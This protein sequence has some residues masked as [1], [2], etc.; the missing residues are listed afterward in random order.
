MVFLCSSLSG[1]FLTPCST[2]E[3]NSRCQPTR[4]QTRSKES[5][6]SCL[7]SPCH[8]PC[9]AQRTTYAPPH[10]PHADE[11][12][13]VSGPTQSVCMC[14]NSLAASE[15]ASRQVAC[16]K[17]GGGGS[18]PSW[19]MIGGTLGTSKISDS[20]C[21][22]LR[23]CFPARAGTHSRCNGHGS[24]GNGAAKNDADHA[25]LPA[26]GALLAPAGCQSNGKTWHE[27]S[28]LAQA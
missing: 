26:W 6:L 12:Q 15:P 24:S 21:S 7:A 14:V 19:W 25:D 8:G 10:P 17:C 4:L 28:L 11:G 13:L 23:R 27:Y 22:H 18:P 20:W 16:C 2:P 3:L 5:Y 1:L 9:L